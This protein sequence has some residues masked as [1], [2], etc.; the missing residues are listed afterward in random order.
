M[1]KTTINP[2]VWKR[3][4]MRYGILMLVGIVLFIIMVPLIHQT[5][6]TWMLAI[7]LLAG[8]ATFAGL[9]GMAVSLFF[10]LWHGKPSE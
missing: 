10:H 4:M 6:D 7:M 3:M 2:K 5:H 9:F 1:S 8:L